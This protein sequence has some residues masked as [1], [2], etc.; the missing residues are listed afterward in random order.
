LFLFLFIPILLIGQG[1]ESERDKQIVIE[2][3]EFKVDSFSI[4][5]NTFK[6]KSLKNHTIPETSYSLNEIESTIEIKDTLLFGDT[7]IFS[8]HV[9]PVLLSKTFYKRKLYFTEP[10]INNSYINRNKNH[11]DN[12]S[13]S[14]LIREGNISRN[15][16]IGN[17]Q[18]L[19]I[20]SN[21]D[22]R[23]NGKLDNDITLQAVISDNNLP[24]Q[25]DGSSYKLQ[26]FDKVFI[27]IFNEKNEIITGD[28]FTKHNSRFLKYNRK[29]KGVILKNKRHM[30]FY[31]YSNLSSISMSKGKYT[32]QSFN[33]DEGN[34]GPYKLRGR[35]GE[36]YVVVLSGTEKLFL[37]GEKLERG[38]DRDYIIDYNTAEIIFTSR[39]LIT[40]DDRFYVEYEYNER[41]Y[42][43]SVITSNQKFVHKNLDLSVHIYSESDWK[44]QN[45]LSEL[46][47]SEKYI[48]SEIGDSESDIY[49]L[50]VDSTTY[51]E[52]KILYKKVDTLINGISLQ[53]YRYSNEPDLAI[54]QIRFT[55][56]NQNE[57]DYILKEDG[58]NGKTYEWT[59]P[60]FTNGNFISQGNF[61]HYVK[62]TSPKSKT[63][64]STEAS[65]KINNK[66]DLYTNITLENFD[67]NLFSNLNDKDNNS[68][69]TF[70]GMK[71]KIIDKDKWKIINSNSLEFISDRYTGINTYKDIEFSRYWNCDNIYGK[72]TLYRSEI[73]IIKDSIELVKYIYQNLDIGDLYS[74]HR[75]SIKLD[76]NKSKFSLFSESKLSKTKSTEFNSTLL[77]SK[78]KIN[79]NLKHLN[80]NLILNSENF[81]NK[82]LENELL[83]STNS[84]VEIISSASNKLKSVFLEI[85]RRKDK[86]IFDFSKSNQ[87]NLNLDFN[88]LN[89]FKYNT[90]LKYRSVNYTAD[91]LQDENHL[92][93]SNNFTIKLFKNFIQFNNKYELGKGKQAKKDKS[94]IKVPSGMGTH[95]WIDN[96]N[97][98]IQELNEFTPAVFQDEAE[99]VVLLLPSNSLEDIYF[100]EY[101]QNI[102][103]DFNKISKRKILKKIY[104]HSHYQIQNKDKDLHFNPFCHY[105]TDSSIDNMSQ[106]INSFSY[107]RNNKFFNLHFQN[108]NS[109]IKNSFSYG[110][111]KQKKQENQ[112]RC[113]N[114]IRNNI[115][116]IIQISIGKKE[117]FSNFFDNKNYEYSFTKLEQHL[118]FE[119]KNNTNFSLLYTHQNKQISENNS[120]VKSNEFSCVYE[121]LDDNNF[122][123]QSHLKLIYIDAILNNN[124]ILNYEL[125]EGLSKGRNF[126]W[127]IKLQKKLKN[128]LQ[129][130][131]LYD[132]RKSTTSEVKHVGNIGVT[133]FF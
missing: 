93:S 82:N 78:S 64:I 104:L 11:K 21:I 35:N 6:I 72:Q 132:G 130:D 116:N 43:Q 66:L 92:L 119:M 74:A 122:M 57:G 49:S 25:E 8:Y 22:L 65:S 94:F 30:E 19:S 36:N 32:T 120:Q 62:I 45:Y 105:I 114:L 51:S 84:F 31:S 46:S 61:A 108:K 39:N 111:D 123:L 17:S 18:D 14:N 107:N 58:V 96:N 68:L 100:L 95:N 85:E 15:V 67:K 76:Y 3:M 28:I 26:E 91:S 102:T 7:L 16:M 59:P 13:N 106:S 118:D 24:F 40:K 52:E 38:I 88:K 75:N 79:Y 133:A 87:I 20:L 103:A 125:M 4:V 101:K 70:L 48:L 47:D 9:F 41:S 77:F 63:I 55:E 90:S 124:S 71:Y 112:I 81:L 10:E 1:F 99:Y 5:S 60:I 2:K 42:A 98:G 121:K 69:T 109:I 127:G 27:R 23:I 115:Y 37:N 131:L 126:I 86:K 110:T 44:N 117:N 12:R 80:L 113:N 50:S 56:V 128:S 29:A 33:G 83:E 53:F 97:N 129:I 89:Y 54:Y 34:Q 73:S